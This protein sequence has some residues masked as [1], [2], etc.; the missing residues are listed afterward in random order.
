MVYYYGGQQGLF[1]K[2]KDIDALGRFWVVHDF[3]LVQEP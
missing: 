1:T 2:D 3:K